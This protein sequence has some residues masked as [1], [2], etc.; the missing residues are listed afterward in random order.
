MAAGVTSRGA[1]SPPS[2]VNVPKLVNVPQGCVEPLPQF[3]LA[4][5]GNEQVAVCVE[6]RFPI[7]GLFGLLGDVAELRRGRFGGSDRVG[8][9]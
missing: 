6:R 3:G 8:R 7:A 4:A 1:P 5:V 9:A 2:D